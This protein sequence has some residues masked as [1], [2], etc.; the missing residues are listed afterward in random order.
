MLSEECKFNDFIKNVRANDIIELMYLTEK[1]ATEADRLRY[2]SR[3]PLSSREKCGVY[4]AETL[5]N[6]L[7][8][9]RYQIRPKGVS[10]E[11][12][13]TFLQAGHCLSKN[14]IT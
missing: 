12:F 10:D 14:S 6:F 13:D 9:L 2:R 3:V 1:E 8:Y 5:K 11:V 4:Y 7:Y